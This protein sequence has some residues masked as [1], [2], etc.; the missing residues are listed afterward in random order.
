MPVRV[1]LTV[2]FLVH[3][4]IHILGFIVP[5][6]LTQIRGLPYKTTALY[7]LFDL[8]P[9]GAR[10]VGL[11]W[12]LA[13]VGF[14]VAAAAVFVDQPWWPQIAFW[15]AVLSLALGLLGL[16]ESVFGALLSG[17][18]IIYLTVVLKTGFL[19]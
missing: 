5:W 13:A 2:L 4:L 15:T 10:A 11:F 19:F 3:G 6:N 12:L 17:L 14:V 16:P 18:I 7:G 1:I 8:G 9:G